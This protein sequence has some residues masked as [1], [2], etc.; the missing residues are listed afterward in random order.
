MG[1][2]KLLMISWKGN[3]MT[4]QIDKNRYYRVV[5]VGDLPEG[6]RLIFELENKAIVLFNVKGEFLATGDLCSHDEGPI[7]DGELDGNVIICP[8]HGAR[9][10]VHTG[11]ALSLPAVTGIPVYPIRVVDEF[12]EI[13]IPQ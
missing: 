8:R 3:E 9:F 13:G 10:D 4:D 7:G 5:K 2:E 11:K 1:W 6:E 12:I